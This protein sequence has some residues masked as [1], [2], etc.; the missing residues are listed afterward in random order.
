MVKE[1]ADEMS[2]SPHT[3]RHHL[4]SIHRKLGVH[5][6]QQAVCV[7]QAD[8]CTG[9]RMA[10]SVLYANRRRARRGLRN[11]LSRRAQQGTTPVAVSFY[12][13][14]KRKNTRKGARSNGLLR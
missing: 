12:E 5:S 11:L 9:C 4:E 13:R 10:F 8:R 3:V 1:L 6:L 2:L 7:L 14:A